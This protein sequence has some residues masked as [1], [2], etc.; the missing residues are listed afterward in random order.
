MFVIVKSFKLNFGERE[1]KN[2]KKMLDQL[3]GK[4]KIQQNTCNL[5]WFQARNNKRKKKERR[6]CVTTSLHS[7]D[8]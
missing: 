7:Q 8:R 6:V 1:K 3:E 4:E 5:V 2:K